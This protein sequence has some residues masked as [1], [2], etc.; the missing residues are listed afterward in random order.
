[1]PV[2]WALS[3]FEA[4]T[5]V[6]PMKVIQGATLWAAESIGK[7]KDLGSVEAGK[8]ADVIVIDRNP[9]DTIETTQNIRVVMKDGLVVDTTYD[10]HF[11]NP[12][13]RPVDV[14]PQR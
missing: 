5:G 3:R 1:L 14:P 13:P 10:P 7:A 12:L 2:F 4:D 6:P 8:L 9:L 11:V